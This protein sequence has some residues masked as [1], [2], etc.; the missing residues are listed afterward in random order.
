MKPGL[1]FFSVQVERDVR[2]PGALT[3]PGVAL[4]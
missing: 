1:L 2:E 3:S 4:F